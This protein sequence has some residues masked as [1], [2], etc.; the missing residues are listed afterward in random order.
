MHAGDSLVEQS[1]VD[2][3]HPAMAAAAAMVMSAAA[4]RDVQTFAVAIADFEIAVR[5]AAYV[6]EHRNRVGRVHEMPPIDIVRW[7]VSG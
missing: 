2:G 7:V 1:K 4:T 6:C 3:R 5:H